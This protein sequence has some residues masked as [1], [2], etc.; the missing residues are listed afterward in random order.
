M[1]DSAA[2]RF[3]LGCYTASSGGNGGGVSVFERAS[4]GEPWKAI[5]VAPVDDP[6]FIA[7]TE[8]EL[9]ATSETTAGRLVSFTVSAGELQP[10]SIAASGGTAPC[11]VVLDPASGSLVVT[12]Y[13]AGT[14]AA[15][16][17]DAL[18]PARVARVL[19]LPA[20]HGVVADRQE[21]PH[22]HS[23]TPTP[24]GTLLVSDLGTDRLY[25]VRID[26][27][28][29]EPSFVAAHAMPA[30]SGPR[31]FAWLG[32]RLLVTGELDGN[33]HVLDRVGDGFVVAQSVH[34]YDP[35]QSHGT[36]E[37]LLSH[38]AVYEGRVYVA[39]RGRDT[40]SVLAEAGGTVDG[41]LALVA[42]VPC[43]GR[44]PRHFAFDG[45]QIYVANQLG[46]TVTILPLDAVTGI[47]GPVS[48][49]IPT[50]SPSCVLFP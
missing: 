14:F 46:D 16:S 30:G 37:V 49:S 4:A 6:S 24:W 12:N 40:I 38:I 26:S 23:S 22:A 9:H 25:E 31:H 27:T 19:P 20:G 11:H 42:E 44:W 7:L 8:G 32:D 34:G 13:T 5:Q 47:P 3:Y 48:S 50:G 21:A 36:G 2:Q 18:D 43:G 35:T 41:P 39:V 15:L 33:V 10:A 45:S 1:S 29:L 17:A 28:T